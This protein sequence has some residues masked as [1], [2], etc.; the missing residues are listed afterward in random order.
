MVFIVCMVKLRNQRVLKMFIEEKRIQLKNEKEAFIRNPVKT[1]A[2]EMITF[3]RT[4][5][6]ETPYLLRYPEEFDFL[7]ESTESFWLRHVV[8]SQKEAMLVCEMDGKIVGNC[9][10]E[11]NDTLKTRHRASIGISVLKEYWNL[12]I[13][14]YFMNAMIKIAEENPFILQ[15]E[16]DYI[17]GNTRARALYEKMGFRICGILPNAYQLKDGTLLNE[18][19]M[20]KV[21][22]K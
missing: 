18:Y 2:N 8:V 17:E 4:V 9:H 13:G 5:S 7:N 21:L 20:M 6:S 11:W 10:I 16:L 19:K 3:L 12:G 1:E 14:T 15:I 22:K